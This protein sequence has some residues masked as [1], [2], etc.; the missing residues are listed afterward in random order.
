MRSHGRDVKTS[1]V[2]RSNS[3]FF[4]CH[5]GHLQVLCRLSQLNI[6]IGVQAITRRMR[7]RYSMMR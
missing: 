1:E 7:M 2:V 5:T 4:G 6:W 3:F